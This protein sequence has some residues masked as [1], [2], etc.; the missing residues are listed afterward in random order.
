M[1]P[2]SPDLV[3]A[4]LGALLWSAIDVVRVGAVGSLASEFPA[5]F[6]STALLLGVAVVSLRRARPF[7]DGLRAV[8]AGAAMASFPL[9]MFAAVLERSTHHRALGG[10]TFAFI[11]AAVLAFAIAFAW[12]VLGIARQTTR[13]SIARASLAMASIASGG[14]TAAL[15]LL[16]ARAAPAAPLM[17]GVVDGLIGAALLGLVAVPARWLERLPS[18]LGAMAWLCV[19]VAGVVVA[20]SDSALCAALAERAPVAFA[21]GAGCGG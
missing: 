9:A 17:A 3:V 6:G 1:P 5:L 4:L 8:A 11:A 18:R 15:V 12:R 20:A 19:V 2:F 14:A 10:V 21:I 16:G 7:G 13:A